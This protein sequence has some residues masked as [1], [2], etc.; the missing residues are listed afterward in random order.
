M[1]LTFLTGRHPRREAAEAPPPSE[2]GAKSPAQAEGAATICLAR[3]GAAAGQR[4]AR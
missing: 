1:K 2:A 4:R 3:P